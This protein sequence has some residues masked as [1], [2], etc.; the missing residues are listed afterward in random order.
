MTQ[1][2]EVSPPGWGHTKAE[3]EKTKPNKPKSKI[4][5]SAHEFDKDLKSGKF[6]GL[7]G[8]KTM[9]DKKASM[10]KLMWSMKNKGDKPH[11]KPGVKDVLKKKYQKEE[12]VDEKPYPPTRLFKNVPNSVVK[13]ANKEANKV[14][15]E[16]EK[17]VLGEPPVRGPSGDSMHSK[18]NVYEDEKV[19]MVSLVQ[20][21]INE[22]TPDQKK[23]REASRTHST[24]GKGRRLHGGRSAAHPKGAMV[25]GK[26]HTYDKPAGAAKK[27]GRQKIV[28]TPVKKE[29]FGL[30]PATVSDKDLGDKI[31][32][33]HDKEQKRRAKIDAKNIKVHGKLPYRKEGTEGD[34]LVKAV[35]NSPKQQ[36]L[37]KKQQELAKK[38]KKED[39]SLA[40]KGKGR[41]AAKALYKD[42][43]WGAVAKFAD[44]QAAA[45]KKKKETAANKKV[46]S[47]A[48]GRKEEVTHFG[49]ILRQAIAEAKKVD[50][51]KEINKIVKT[52]T[53]GKIHNQKVDLFTA[54][55][56]QQVYKA[57]NHKNK[58]KM[59]SVMSKDV[60]GLLKM[61]D[62][63]MSKMKR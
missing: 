29:D 22:L 59:N 43:G 1:L 45:E 21:A 7:P 3:K 4:G 50:A 55:A 46:S 32:K 14:K 6:K 31:N 23:K 33:A 47:W 35:A 61:A 15:R 58:E 38:Q 9:K 2:N 18:D 51:I 24:L 5:G 60:H 30:P 28:A 63:S 57:I 16:Q 17:A 49:D 39:M 13:K 8:D 26:T 37:K 20:Q 52:K 25:S 53:M 10:F 12:K 54:S 62:F 34:A 56:I 36:A 41:K 11:Y 42:E 44:S 48:K 19:D 40:P 27:P